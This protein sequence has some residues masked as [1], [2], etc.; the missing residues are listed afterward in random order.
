MFCAF[1]GNLGYGGGYNDRGVVEYKERRDSDDEYDEFGRRRRKNEEKKRREG[2]SSNS[3]NDSSRRYV[4]NAASLMHENLFEL[5][6][7][8]FCLNES[9]YI[10]SK[11][12]RK[13]ESDESE[14]ERKGEKASG[15]DRKD[16]E[17]DDDDDDDEDDDDGDIDKYKLFDDESEKSEKED[18]SAKTASSDKKKSSGSSTR[19]GRR[20]RSRSKSRCVQRN[21]K[22]KDP[23][24]SKLNNLFL[25]CN[26]FSTDRIRIRR[27][28]A[29]AAVA[30][31]IRR[32]VRVGAEVE[33]HAAIAVVDLAIQNIQ[34]ILGHVRDLIL[35][36]MHAIV[37]DKMMN[38]TEVSATILT[39]LLPPSLPKKHIELCISSL[40]VSGW[41]GCSLKIN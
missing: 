23:N 38:K 20:S 37:V 39:S 22:K 31:V 41:T 18:D 8:R 25:I 7:R 10:Y 35:V 34:D 26:F 15:K 17:E 11:R 24:K 36:R 19:R 16:D 28:V 40:F 14:S 2:S 13:D 33:N 4:H 30:V 32:I 3:R 29:A 21:S 6:T 12:S 27:V 1:I 9:I 5:K